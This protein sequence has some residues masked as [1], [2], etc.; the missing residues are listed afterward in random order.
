M[1]NSR[2]SNVVGFDDAPFQRDHRGSVPIIG[3][4]YADLRFDGVLMGEIEKDG[5]D[6]AGKI[7]DIVRCSRFAGH[8]RLIML[9]GIALGGF[10]VVDVFE[11]HHRLCIPVMIVA[12]KRPDMAAVKNALVSHIDQGRKKWEIIERLGP[13]EPAGNVYIQRVGMSE[14]Q[15]LAVLN[16]FCI[17]GNIPEPIRSAHLIATALVNGQSRGK[18]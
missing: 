2:L 10:N 1:Q 16:R 15:A 18:P 13:M 7:A 11:L 17:H 8:I 3:S 5:F 12:R 14:T 6:A 4:V 9:Q